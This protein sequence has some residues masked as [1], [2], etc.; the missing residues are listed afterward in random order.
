[1]LDLSELF[2]TSIARAL[3]S[4]QVAYVL[5]GHCLLNV[6][7]IPSIIS[8]RILGPGSSRL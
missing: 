8:V 7:G 1:M 4:D 6:H 5:W 3:N 2:V